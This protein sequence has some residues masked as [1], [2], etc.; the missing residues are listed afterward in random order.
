MNNIFFQISSLLAVTVTIALFMRLLRQ[1]LIVAYLV[2]GIVSGPIFLGILHGDTEIYHALSQFGVVL[3]LFMVGLSLNFDHVR[4]IG[5]ASLL[6]GI[7]QVF[8]SAVVGFGLLQMMGY[9]VVS[10]VYLAIAITFSSTIVIV[11]ILSDKR[12]TESTYGR[13][14]IG[15]MIVQ[16]LIAIA[17]LMVVTTISQGNDSLQVAVVEYFIKVLV[18]VG[19]VYFLARFVLPFILERVA[20]SSE[21]LFIF[22]VAWCFGVASILHLLGFSI[23]IGAIIAG[24]TLGSSPFQGEI[25]SRIKPL[26]DFFIVLF[27]IILGA[28]MTVTNIMVSLKPALVL[29]IF[30]LFGNP[31]ILFTVFRRLKFTRRNSFLSGIT[32]AQVSEFGFVLLFTAVRVGHIT[33]SE[34]EIFT[35]IALITIV[36]SSYAVTYNEKLYQFLLPV[37]N[38]FGKDREKGMIDEPGVRYDAWVFGYRRIGWKICE[39]LSDMGASFAVVDFNPR[40]IE[41]LRRQKIKSYFGDVADVEFL[42]EL[43]FAKTKLIVS[44][45]TDVDDQITMIRYIKGRYRNI[46][47]VAT[48]YEQQGIDELYRAGAD[49]VIIPHMLGGSWMGNVISS[50]KWTKKTFDSLRKEQQKD[51]RLH[52]VPGMSMSD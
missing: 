21:F 22:T 3:L 24:L 23:E 43:P 47:I 26:R 42:S 14:T 34:V 29:S 30:V 44:T 31:F 15:L 32:A 38:I 46:K 4:K 9:E 28:E 41:R 27:F 5:K 25:A 8:V 40:A 35:I 10:S 19:M 37:F 51:M 52:D 36:I 7:A 16:D 17:V 20:R 39:S 13:Y 49:Y 33:G 50:K 18:L 1:P 2:A 45:I 11:K 12:D 6:A 48:L